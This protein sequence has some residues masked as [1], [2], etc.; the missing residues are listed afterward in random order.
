MAEHARKAGR[1]LSGC[2]NYQD[3]RLHTAALERKAAH[4]REEYL[5]CLSKQEVKNQ[6]FIAAE[7]LKV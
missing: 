7:D 1:C 4:Q 6:D 3:Q 5:H 2:K